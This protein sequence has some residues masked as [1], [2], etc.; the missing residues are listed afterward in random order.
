MRIEF[1]PQHEGVGKT[2]PPND[3][4]TITL[5]TH[6]GVEVSRFCYDLT[7]L[8]WVPR[9]QRGSKCGH[10]AMVTTQPP[11]TSLTAVAAALLV[12]LTG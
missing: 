11:A 2:K 12:S 1:N 8:F 6:C 10:F 3:V 9:W 4:V 7:G 5:A